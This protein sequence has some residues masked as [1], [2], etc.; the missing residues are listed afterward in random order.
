MH[1]AMQ[2]ACDSQAAF[3]KKLEKRNS[4]IDQLKGQ[5]KSLKEEACLVKEQNGAMQSALATAKD[6]SDE[7]K[8]CQEQLRVWKDRESRILYYLGLFTEITR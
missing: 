8:R 1:A 5:I 2:N 7:H 6:E 4:Q 3:K